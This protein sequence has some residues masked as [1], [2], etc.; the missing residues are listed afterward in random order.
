MIL[1]DRLTF[2]LL[3][4]AS[5]PLVAFALYES[6]NI[7]SSL[8]TATYYDESLPFISDVSIIGARDDG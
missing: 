7:V 4:L 2:A 1:I 3:A 5:L 8:A 6:E